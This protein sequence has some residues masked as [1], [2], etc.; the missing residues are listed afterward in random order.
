AASR[1]ERGAF[2]FEGQMVDSPVLTHAETMLR[3]AGEATSE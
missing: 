1:S 2:A 3:R